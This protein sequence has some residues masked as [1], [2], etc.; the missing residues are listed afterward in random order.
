MN[1]FVRGG[2]SWRVMI[3][4]NSIYANKGAVAAPNTLNIMPNM[5]NCL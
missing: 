2:T 4:C 1:G 3:Y 5:Y